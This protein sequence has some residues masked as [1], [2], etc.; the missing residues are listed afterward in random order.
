MFLC[1]H[2]KVS[3]GKESS[4]FL[5]ATGVKGKFNKRVA[6]IL[7]IIIV[8]VAAIVSLAGSASIAE[9]AIFK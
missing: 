4:T 1:A 8:V 6:A 7:V 2:R 9:S 5:G 3:F